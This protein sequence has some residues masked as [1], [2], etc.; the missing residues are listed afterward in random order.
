[1][2]APRLLL[3]AGLIVLAVAT[4]VLPHPNNFVA[5][6]AV[7]IF[8]GACLPD[9]RWAVATPLIAMF[10]SDLFWLGFHNTVWAVYAAM[11]VNVLIASVLARRRTVGGIA[12]A[13][14]IG[15]VQFW[16]I[17]N[18]AFWLMW[19]DGS[20]G[21]LVKSYVDAIP[22]FRTSLVADGCYVAALFGTLAVAELI[23]PALR[24]A[25][26]PVADDEA[27]YAPALADGKTARYAVKQRPPMTQE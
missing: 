8:A 12:A 23:W 21:M 14:L 11:A 27:G 13:T 17:T 4:R 2:N 15:A 3:I 24:L 10:A 16:L 22:F 19:T 25:P 26:R 9:R 18:A 6:G 1:M 7:A 20:A 5:V